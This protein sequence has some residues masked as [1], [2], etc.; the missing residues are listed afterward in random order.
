MRLAA[1]AFSLL[2]LAACQQDPPSQ[3]ARD[4]S[5]PPLTVEGYGDMAIGMSIADAR[6]ISG[7]PLD[8]EALEPDIPGACSEQQYRTTDG[9]QLWLMFEGDRLTRITASS[10]APRTRTAQNV[11]V[12][13]T[14]TEVR[15]AYQNVIEEGAH[16]S[17]P[18]AHNLLIWTTLDRS[19]LLFEVNEQGVVT[20]VHAGGPSIR[21][22]EGCA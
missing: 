11:G 7:Q 3:G 12:G 10:E 6:R 17:E 13:S 5:V 4:S 1:L 14:D 16:Y 20:A 15:T 18:P 22:M 21:Y 9:D 19:G 2:A 8:N